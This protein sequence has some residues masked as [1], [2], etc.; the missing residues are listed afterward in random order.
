MRSISHNHSNYYGIEERVSRLPHL[1]GSLANLYG[2]TRSFAKANQ[3][4]PTAGKLWAGTPVSDF[5]VGKAKAS[6]TPPRPQVLS[7]KTAT[8]TNAGV[9]GPPGPPAGYRA[10]SSGGMPSSAA[11]QNNL[12]KQPYQ[13]IKDKQDNGN[14]QIDDDYNQSMAMLDQASSGLQGQAGS[15]QDQITNDAAAAQTSL[16]S[17]QTTGEQ[18]VQSSLSTAEGLGKNA[19]QQARDLFRQTNQQNNAQLSALGISS[20][21]VSEALAERLG[22]ET[23]RRIAGVS[24]SLDEVRQNAANEVGRIKNYYSE[25]KVQLDEN[26][27]IQKDQI[28]QS[29]MQ[30]LNQINNA[31]G[32]ASQAKSSARANLISQVQDQVYQLTAQQQQFDQALREWAQQKSAALTPIAQDQNYLN[33]VIS[34]MQNLQTNPALS[35]FNVTAGINQNAKSQY[36]SSYNIVPKKKP[37]DDPLAELYNQAGI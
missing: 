7:S 23:A 12:P 18:G 15:A 26:V 19:L 17:A 24:G 21:S 35:G 31:R 6:Y 13:S 11:P 8:N 27:R 2:A 3:S 14:N 22:V 33:S 16:G 1:L 9:M 36:S 20:S 25:R 30:G 37:Q 4:S 32:Q 10:P 29:L 34:N 5:L 28:Q